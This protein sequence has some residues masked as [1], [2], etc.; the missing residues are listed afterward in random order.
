MPNDR[1]RRALLV[2]LLL[3]CVVVFGASLRMKEA[4]AS[5]AL[6]A[7]DPYTHVV[8]T[9]EALARGWFGDS[10]YLG[11]QMYPPGLHAIGGVLAPL[12]GVSLY[13]FA[14]FSPVAFGVLAIL[15]MYALGRRLDGPATG[16]AAAAIVA[17]MPEHVFRTDLYFPT[18]LDLAA[19]PAF[20]LLYHEA[21]V[22]HDK[23]Q[24][25]PALAFLLV[26]VGLSFAHPW[27]VPLFAGPA[28][29]YALL[30]GL[31]TRASWAR[32]APAAAL[33]VVVSAFAMASRWTGSDTGFVDFLA[34][35]PVLG[36]LSGVDVPPTALLVLVAAALGAASAITIALV[37]AASRV[38]L[39]PTARIALAAA[40]ALAALVA[41]LLLA[42]RPLPENVSYG[43]QLG[44]AIVPLALAGV[45]LALV[46]PT[47]A[48][49]LALLSALLLFPLTALDVFHGRYWPQRTVAY[50]CIPVALLAAGSVA[51]AFQ[52]AVASLGRFRSR[53][54]AA[55][56]AMGAAVLLAA[57][58][59]EA[60]PH[61]Y[62]WYRL[63]V[64]DDFHAFE[65]TVHALDAAGPTAQAVVESWQPALILKTLGSPDQ[66]RY[67]PAF[68]R[69]PEARAKI[70]AEDHV[71]LFVVV[72][73][74]ALKDAS[75][76]KA[77]TSFL[78][79]GGYRLVDR[80]PNATFRLYEVTG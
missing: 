42:A 41:V 79:E 72:D 73:K 67:S 23:V 58:A 63:Y 16:L 80:S 48:G 30:R 53:R 75:R 45:V 31:R 26:G 32:L 1:A 28:F 17:V 68:F 8:L 71:A 77:D 33:A 66:V 27:V 52:R 20:L 74:F 62:S 49:D 5:P 55:P 61:P 10:Y 60:R 4:L 37:V 24:A 40:L 69:D 29:G 54:V 9:K 70:L 19:L 18:A 2:G 25:G 14:R 21:V 13:D 6:G 12:A 22:A 39:P 57:G 56:F 44:R 11:I 59:V 3:A 76:G 51:W 46:R 64:D 65:R 15:G 50:L 35:I 34:R 47:P 78:D 38:R 7:E 36:R 43:A